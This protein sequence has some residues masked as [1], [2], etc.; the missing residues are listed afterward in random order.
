MGPTVS[1]KDRK[2]DDARAKK[3]EAATE[4]ALRWLGFLQ[5]YDVTVSFTDKFEGTNTPTQ[6]NARLSYVYPYHS[7]AIVW[8]RDY[9]DHA[10]PEEIEE[11]AIHEALHVLLLAG[12]RTLAQ[13]HL[14][15]AEYRRVCD[16]EE[17]AVDLATHY[18][19]RRRPQ[20]GYH[21]SGVPNTKK[22]A[23][24]PKRRSTR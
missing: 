2:T 19:M 11:S 5:Q 16:L 18:L 9:V 10:T 1:G 13:R 3:V 23:Q 21:P 14:P 20:Y 15:D 24:E 8:R 4:G 7:V 17:H 22:T 12:L 6:P